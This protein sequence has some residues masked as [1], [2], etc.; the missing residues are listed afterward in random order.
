MKFH[1]LIVGRT[2]E[3]ITESIDELLVKLNTKI[4]QQIARDILIVELKYNFLF[5][6]LIFRAIIVF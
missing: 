6:A 2:I 3:L 4:L 1:Y 5:I